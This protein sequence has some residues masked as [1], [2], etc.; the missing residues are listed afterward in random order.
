MTAMRPDQLCGNLKAGD[1]VG[2]RFPNLTVTPLHDEPGL[3]FGDATDGDRLGRHRRHRIERRCRPLRRT[4]DRRFF[5]PPWAR[6]RSA[7][8]LIRGAGFQRNVQRHL[9]RYGHPRAVPQHRSEVGNASLQSGGGKQAMLTFPCSAVPNPCPTVTANLRRHHSHRQEPPVPRLSPQGWGVQ[10]DT[11]FA[12]LRGKQAVRRFRSAL[13]L[14]HGWKRLFAQRRSVGSAC[15]LGGSSTL[16][17]DAARSP[18]GR[19]SPL[20]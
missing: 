17:S 10:A 9:Q 3:Q 4:H 11:H 8:N 7:F 5:T 14:W 18:V 19:S 16:G 20:P 15:R 12:L 6:A 2:V 1:W 13:L